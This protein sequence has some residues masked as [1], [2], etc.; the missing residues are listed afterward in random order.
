MLRASR[1]FMFSH[2]LRPRSQPGHHIVIIE[3]IAQHLV[4]KH[5]GLLTVFGRPRPNAHDRHAMGMPSALREV[6]SA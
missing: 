5:A 4:K 2:G 3:F 6:I 1:A